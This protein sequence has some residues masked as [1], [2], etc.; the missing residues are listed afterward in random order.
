MYEDDYD[1]MKAAHRG[2]QYY[3]PSKRTLLNTPIAVI[4]EKNQEFNALRDFL[5]YKMKL[6]SKK[7]R[8]LADELTLLHPWRRTIFR[9]YINTVDFLGLYL[10]QQMQA[11]EFMRALYGN[12]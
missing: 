4:N 1:K 2:K 3:I 12:V 6:L 5:I 8:T 7:E 9:R 10:H 11:K